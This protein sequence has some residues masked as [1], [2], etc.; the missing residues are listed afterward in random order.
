GYKIMRCSNCKGKGLINCP[1]CVRGHGSK[2]GYVKKDCT[3]CFD[4]RIPCRN[5][6]C[7]NGWLNETCSECNGRKQIY[8][9]CRKCSGSGVCPYC[10]GIGHRP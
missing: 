6:N 7:K 1:S 8:Y 5:R 4:S 10:H 9:P 3:N 2:S